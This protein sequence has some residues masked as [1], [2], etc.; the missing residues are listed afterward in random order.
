MPQD[1]Y[2][3]PE[4]PVADPGPERAIAE[5]PWQVARAVFLLWVSYAFAFPLVYFE[6]QR[7]PGALETGVIVFW[8]LLFA[9]AA[10]LNVFIWRGANWARITYLVLFLLSLAG[11]W[12]TAEETL[13]GSVLEF[14]LNGLNIG[15]DSVALYWLFT[16]PGRLWFRKAA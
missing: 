12:S 10:A 1:P 4:S 6:A 16:S 11:F 3:P 14:L 15:L 5:R 13:A 8:A 9:F 7:T 2:T